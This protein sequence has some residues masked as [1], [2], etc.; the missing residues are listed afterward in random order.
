MSLRDIGF[1]LFPEAMPATSQF[2]T[3]ARIVR[4][5]GNKGEVSAELFTDFPE[6]LK[7]VKELFLSHEKAVPR[8]VRLKSFWVDR[9]HPEFGIFHFEGVNAISEAEKLRGLEIQ[10]PIEQRVALPA[11]KYFVSDLIGCSAFEL[12]LGTA[13][14][15]SSPCSLAEVPA[16]VGTV[17]D[18]YFP[19]ESQPGTPLLSVDTPTGEL[20]IPLAEDICRKIDI[21]ARRI[22]VVLPEGL[23]D[24]NRL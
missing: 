24:T 22:E 7:R 20:L 12:P 15:A 2:V 8:S 13:A 14:V 1:S 10:I 16:L 19:G 17:R 6:R 4:P 3:I 21:T 11:G 5:R 23:R 18:V 9:N